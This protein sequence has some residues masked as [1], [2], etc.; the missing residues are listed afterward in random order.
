MDFSQFRD[1]QPEKSDE[2]LQL[3][4]IAQNIGSHTYNYK[5]GVGEDPSQDHIGPTAQELQ[6]VP[7]LEAAVKENPETGLLEVD[8]Q[9]IALASIGLLAALAR[10][11]LN[12][13]LQGE[14]ENAAE[15][16]NYEL[17]VKFPEYGSAAT[18]STTATE[19]TTA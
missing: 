17:D 10:K 19:T 9:F 16:P 8:T 4:A 18:N 11:V 3:E 5:D 15:Q 14:E 13:P 6:Q 7:G 12:I 2:E 1:F